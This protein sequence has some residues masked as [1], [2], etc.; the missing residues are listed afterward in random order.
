[1]EADFAKLQQQNKEYKHQAEAEIKK[2][3][4]EN[5]K[6]ME[7]IERNKVEADKIVADMSEFRNVWGSKVK[8]NEISLREIMKEQKELQG[9]GLGQKV[10][11]VLRQNE[12]QVNE[13]VERKKC[14]VVFGDTERDLKD[15]NE[16]KI[17]EIRRVDDIL[18]VLDEEEKGW[19]DEVEDSWRLGKY[20]KGQMRPIKIKFK[21]ARVAEEVLKSSWKLS[22]DK[23]Y[24]DI[25]IRKDLNEEERENMREVSRE[26]R[27]LNEKRTEEDKQNFYYRNMDGKIR[28]W[29]I[30]RRERRSTTEVRQQRQG[31]PQEQETTENQ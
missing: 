11:T 14:V 8:E 22:Q 17:A 26:V 19:R 29:Y 30:S 20:T 23:K 21:T 27:E 5:Q 4:E 13:I 24:E 9:A 31:S 2:L 1:M 16:R 18:S 3:R 12:K 10:V 15:R 28:K 6:L 7:K 25:R